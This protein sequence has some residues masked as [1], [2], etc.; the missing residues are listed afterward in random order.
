MI[1]KYSN[2]DIEQTNGGAKYL[3]DENG[4]AN[5]LLETTGDYSV[6][7]GDLIDRGVS[8]DI[9]AKRLDIA[10][11]GKPLHISIPAEDLPRY[12]ALFNRAGV[13]LIEDR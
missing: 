2:N 8:E 4:T 3:I 10:Q 12:R 9:I 11:S 1:I 7:L 13:R 6:Y 5:I